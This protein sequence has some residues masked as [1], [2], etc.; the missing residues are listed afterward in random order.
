MT[1]VDPFSIIEYAFPLISH[2]V[3]C[4]LPFLSSQDY[5]FDCPKHLRFY[6]SRHGPAEFGRELIPRHPDGDNADY[7]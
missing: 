4:G 6:D 3:E 1:D 7:H 2:D 5:R